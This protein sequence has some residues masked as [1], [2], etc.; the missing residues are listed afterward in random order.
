MLQH[1][2]LR[3]R[4]DEAPGV[5]YGIVA[6]LI[7]VA[8][9]L[10]WLGYLRL[11]RAALP[12][13]RLESAVRRDAW[14]L[15]PLLLTLR[16][17]WLPLSPRSLAL[18]VAGIAAAKLVLCPRE[19]GLLVVWLLR[20]AVLEPVRGALARLGGLRPRNVADAA[21]LAAAVA[22][23]GYTVARAAT[24]SFTGDESISYLHGVRP[25]LGA[26]LLFGFVDA[27]NHLLNTVLMTVSSHIL[28]AGEFSLRLPN[29]LAHAV[30]LLATYAIARRCGSRVVAMAGF[31][32]L[33]VNP[34]LL[35]F[36]SLARGYGLGLGFL[37]LSLAEAAGAWRGPSGGGRR[38]RALWLAVL[39][40]L[41]NLSF[42]NYYVA[43]LT[44][45]WVQHL[46]RTGRPFP[47][48]AARRA[49][50]DQLVL[51]LFT[52]GF[53]IH[54]LWRGGKLYYGGT[55]GLWADTATS[56]IRGTLYGLDPPSWAGGAIALGLLVLA[57][58][59]VQGRRDGLVAGSLLL[60]TLALAGL[61]LQHQLLGVRYLQGRTALLVLPLMAI[62]A[63]AVLDRAARPARRG[64]AGRMLAMVAAVALLVLAGRTANLTHT[65]DWPQDADTRQLVADLGDLHEATGG[66]RLEATW[67]LVP[68]IEY[69]R[70]TR[71]LGWMELVEGREGSGAPDW[72]YL[73]P[74]DPDA[75]EAGP[76]RLLR[77]YEVSGNVLIARDP[78]EGALPYRVPVW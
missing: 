69:Y 33:N 6:P 17:L 34:F 3:R 10:L 72:L 70:V 64:I 49:V 12:A 43:L 42:L 46:H 53:M 30:Y 16:A 5:R 29:L 48:R 35:D 51:L 55:R 22:L 32:L 41:S 28:G 47:G 4:P 15:L 78:A 56:L 1:D 63:T 20:R 13:S 75:A 23:L 7:A 59:A 36:F 27:N 39:A 62:L 50:L 60:V 54:Q 31:V 73:A 65:F 24:L 38:L 68:A 44:T 61:W 58:A 19:T 76:E 77:R 71:A 57:L 18:V 37:A 52:A 26:S 21:L 14:T 66:E 74:G 45:F 11:L 8:V 25:G 67:F 9:G 40:T 2:W